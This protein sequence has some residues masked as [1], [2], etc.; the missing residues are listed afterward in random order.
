MTY[1]KKLIMRKHR[2]KAKKVEEKQKLA[3]AAA[4]TARRPVPPPAK[5][6]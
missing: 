3:R 6:A 2:I 4:S 5:S 1:R